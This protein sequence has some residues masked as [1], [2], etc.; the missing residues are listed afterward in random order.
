MADTGRA[1]SR[2][3]ARGW[4]Q[5]AATLILLPSLSYLVYAPFMPV[6]FGPQVVATIPFAGMG[7]NVLTLLGAI[8]IAATVGVWRGSRWG[9]VAGFVATGLLLAQAVL[10]PILLGIL[11]GDPPG[12]L[13][14]WSGSLAIPVVC[15]SVVLFA[16][17]RRWTPGGSR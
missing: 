1:R 16:L 5:A 2:P 11:H 7:V 9:R 15:G 12:T 8:G 13:V 6:P 14:S 17:A 4:R 3:P 10:L